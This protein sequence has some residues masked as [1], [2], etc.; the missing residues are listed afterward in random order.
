MNTQD[1]NKDV[2]ILKEKL[3]TRRMTAEVI[4]LWRKEARENSSLLDNIW[5]NNTKEHKVA[6][7]LKKEKSLAWEEN[8][9]IYIDRQIYI[10][11]NKKL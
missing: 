2:Q 9:I 6:Q 4:V 11:N 3:W 5:R 10:P 8:R 1:N 7:K